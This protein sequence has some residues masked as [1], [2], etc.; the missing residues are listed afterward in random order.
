MIVSAQASGSP[1]TYGRERHIS[2]V[3]DCHADVT[4][5]ATLVMRMVGEVS[6]GPKLRPRMESVSE[7]RVDGVFGLQYS[8]NYTGHNYVDL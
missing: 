2:R 6:D 8:H 7:P 1:P 4:Q 3:A 5:R